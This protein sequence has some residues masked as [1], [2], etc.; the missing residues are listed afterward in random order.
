MALHTPVHQLGATPHPHVLRNALIAVL[1]AAAALAI[2]AMLIAFRPFTSSSSSTPADQ[3]ITP[4]SIEF[5]ASE[6]QFAY[7]WQYTGPH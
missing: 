5:R 1:I 7:P 3:I 6:R 4:Q 2:L